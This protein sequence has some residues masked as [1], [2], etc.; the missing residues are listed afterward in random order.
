MPGKDRRRRLG[1]A[2]E[3]VA[4]RFLEEKGLK[5]LDRNW[6]TGSGE[7]DIVAGDGT[8]VVFVEVKTRLNTSY[9]EPEESITREKIER[10][11]RLA[12]AYM[13]ES[14]LKGGMRFDVISV[15]PDDTG[16]EWSV[17]HLKDAF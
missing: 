12:I 16:E 10:I 17:R 15:L 14:G 7:L 13:N 4:C 2:G 1:G 5:I 6:R 8:T 3:E 9:G 11:R